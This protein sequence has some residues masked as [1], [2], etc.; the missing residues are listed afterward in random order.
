MMKHARLFLA[1]MLWLSMAT[2]ATAQS[3]VAEDEF[4]LMNVGTGLYLK[5]G[6]AGNAKAAEGHAG[7]AITLAESDN[8]YTI[9]TSAGY[10]DG[11]LNM[12]STTSTTSTEWTFVV[13]DATNKYYHIKN[14]DNNKYLASK[15]DENGLLELQAPIDG[16]SISKQKWMLVT[17]NQL[18]YLFDITP[19]IKA[20]SFDKNDNTFDINDNTGWSGIKN[21]MIKS[22]GV[23]TDSEN[24]YL[25]IDGEATVTQNIGNNF[26][27]STALSFYANCTAGS[28]SVTIKS[29]NSST[30][31]EIPTNSKWERCTKQVIS[32]GNN[33]GKDII[34][35]ITTTSGTKLSIDN[36]EIQYINSETATSTTFDAQEQA[37]YQA[38]A[39]REIA[40]IRSE[41]KST[42]NTSGTDYFEEVTKGLTLP[43]NDSEFREFLNNINQIKA[44]ALNAKADPKLDEEQKE[45]KAETGF[46]PTITVARN[47][48]AGVW[49]TFVV[50]FD[51]AIP[52]GWKVKKLESS[53][54]NNDNISLVFVAAD[55]IKAG[56]PYMVSVSE[57]VTEITLENVNLS[58]TLKNTTTDDVEFIGTYTNGNVPA[59][60]FFISNNTFYRAA[61]N[62]NTM[63]AFRA[64]LMPLT[65]EGQAALSLSYRTDG[66]T[67]AI[68]NSQLANDNEATVVAIYN[69]QGVRLDDMQEGVNILQM[70]DGRV[71][72]VIIK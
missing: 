46:Y 33:A 20:A 12:T 26:R 38:R 63:K 57:A 58:T 24:Y 37:Q 17:R 30:K 47:I 36:F 16:V 59:G 56:V 71:V 10:L 65:G 51:M 3:T 22:N 44:N 53:S 62:S 43:K 66:E 31:I 39:E 67:T 25:Q 70:S 60:A 19:T 11:A 64:Y 5:F 29:H 23:G 13:A 4:Y 18:S 2:M 27:G 1:C 9:E 40:D 54:R 32:I 72:K 34:L 50:P 69:L 28:A 68:D 49:N 45:Q 61:D 48:K 14:N 6:G 21:D 55:G 52:A 7:T 35:T 41:I 42:N 15:N 8:G